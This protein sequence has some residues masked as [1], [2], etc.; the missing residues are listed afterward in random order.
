M[1]R[2]LYS[3]RLAV[4][5]PGLSVLADGQTVLVSG[6]ADINSD[7]VRIENFR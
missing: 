1:S 3:L 7:L 2:V 4:M 6:A 5:M